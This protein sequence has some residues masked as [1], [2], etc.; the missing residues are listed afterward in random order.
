M[1]LF[2]FLFPINS[3]PKVC[4]QSVNGGVV[5]GVVAVA[6]ADAVVVNGVAVAVAAAVVAVAAD[7]V[8]AD[9]IQ[10]PTS[11]I[12]HWPFCC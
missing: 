2:C 12:S 5:D 9:S 6:V 1:L 4:C 11:K 10:F 7:A 8:V 3:Q